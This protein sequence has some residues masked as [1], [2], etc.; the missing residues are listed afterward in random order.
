MKA[1]LFIDSSDVPSPLKYNTP[2]NS[3]H[4]LTTKIMFFNKGICIIGWYYFILL[5][6]FTKKAANFTISGFSEI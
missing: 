5:F 3:D 6:N 2:Q 4:W 1:F